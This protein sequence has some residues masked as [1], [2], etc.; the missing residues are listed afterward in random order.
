MFMFKKSQSRIDY[1]KI[2]IFLSFC[3][4]LIVSKYYLN[5]YDK[6]FEK[7]GKKQYHIM[8]KTDAY[9]YLSHGAEI[10]KDLED[11]KNFF[12]TGREHFTKYLPPRLAAAYY[13]FLDIDLFNNFE[14]KK[15]N[16]GIHFPYLILQCLFYYISLFFL[17]LVISKKIEKKICLPIVLFLALEP[18]IFQ[19][20]GTF[21]TES[22]FFTLQIIILILILR[23]NLNFYNFFLIGI[24]LSLLS[25][26]KQVAYFYIFPIFF[27]YLLYLKKK[28]Y[29]KLL[30]I[31]FGFFLVQMLPGYNNFVRS[32]KFYLLTADTKTAVYHNII[33]PIIVKSNNITQNKF[34]IAE[35]KIALEWLKKNSIKFD[36]SKINMEESLYPFADYRKSIVSESDKIKYDKFFG[37]RTIK[38]LLDNPWASF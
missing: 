25:L 26:Q 14:E 17:Y 31:L 4:S 18:T 20:H 13:Y 24:F 15:I 8:I 30:F 27:Y 7:D 3:I 19:Y 32:G 29:Y 21:W 36:T 6:Y 33:R 11:G 37:E 5:N 34:Y 12:E 2:F 10:K 35:G 16:L 1:I 28:E 38:L 22:F 23:D 9:R